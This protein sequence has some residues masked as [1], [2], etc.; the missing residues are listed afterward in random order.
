MLDL[1]PHQSKAFDD[2]RASMRSHRSTLLQAACGFG[3]TVLFAHVVKRAVAK[4]KRV[5][6]AVHRKELIFQTAA[7]FDKCDIEY[8]FIAAGRHCDRRA[9][10]YIAS[11][12]TLR[13]RL[14]DFACDLLIVDEAHLSMAATWQQ[15]VKHYRERGA[16]V[17][18]CTASPIRLDGKGLGGNFGNMVRGPSTAWLME[19]DYLSKYIMFAP[20][21]ADT[22]GLRRMAGDFRKDDAAALMNRPSITGC[23]ISHWLKHAP[24]RKTVAY[25]VS[26]EHSKAIAQSFRDAGVP[27]MH[28]D[29]ETDETVRVNAMRDLADGRLQVVTNCQLMTE[30]VDLSALAGKPVSIECVINLRPT[31]S[32]ALWTQICGRALRPKDRPAIILDHA[33]CSSTLGYPD[34]DIEWS[35]T[36]G[37]PVRKKC[38]VP[39]PRICPSCFAASRSGSRTCTNCGAPFPVEAREVVQVEGE[40]AEVSQTRKVRRQINPV[41]TLDGLRE[42]AAKRGYKPGWADHV[43]AAR[44]AKGAR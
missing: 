13:N 21:T 19:N 3:K 6:F 29:G 43:W 18:G 11:I 31:Q 28:V 15:C 35:L 41:T 8:S 9:Q 4:G 40:L 17:L 20:Q 2:L 36:E 42:L 34:D 39:A 25:A 44:Q 33:G 1:Y 32:L 10:V 23:A 14:D 12:P 16:Y 5:I 24:G 30:G 26:I 27:S 22:G 7:T 38:E 37:E